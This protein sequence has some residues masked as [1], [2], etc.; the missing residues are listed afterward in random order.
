MQK[1][2][3]ATL[4]YY[5]LTGAGTS[6]LWKPRPDGKM[7]KTSQGLNPV[8]IDL[9]RLN[10]EPFIRGRLLFQVMGYFLSA[11]EGIKKARKAYLKEIKTSH[12]KSEKADSSLWEEVKDR[13]E[14][15][16][17]GL[18]GFAPVDD[19]LI[20]TTDHSGKIDFLY[21]NA[22]VLG[23]EMDFSHIQDAPGPKAG[24]EAQRV[25]AQLGIATN[26]IADFIRSRGYGA[27]ACHPYGGPALYPAM[28]V[29]AGLG[30]MGRHGMLISKKFGPRQRLSMITTNA[31]PLPE[32]KKEDLGISEF[33]EKCGLC[34]KK[35]PVGAIYQKPVKKQSST[36]S[37]VDHEKCGTFFYDHD[38]C[39]VCIKS[40]PF[41]KNGYGK[42]MRKKGKA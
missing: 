41:H 23:M 33:C 34:I 29:R 35:C 40:C 14:S 16:G 11:H 38:G 8:F 22:I 39:S 6:I 3:R 21:E 10:I 7:W 25:Y 13:A 31:G 20:F 19:N 12:K 24:L 37:C 32:T 15:L 2:I 42:I 27:I 30:Q 4:A 5:E 26:K 36:V 9:K 28:A 18:V 17:V 1:A